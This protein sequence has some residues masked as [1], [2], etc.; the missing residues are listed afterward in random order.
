MN[1]NP[2]CL[3]CPESYRLLTGESPVLVTVLLACKP[4]AT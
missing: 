2:P 3:V 1:R 4:E